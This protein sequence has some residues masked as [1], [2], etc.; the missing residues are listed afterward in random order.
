MRLAVRPWY[1]ST[2]RLLM[3]LMGEKVCFSLTGRCFSVGLTF[4]SRGRQTSMP[5]RRRNFAKKFSVPVLRL[6]RGLPSTYPRIP[7]RKKPAKSKPK[8]RLLMRRMPEG[9]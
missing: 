1:L 8:T 3:S 2:P 6:A 9:F 5:N 7:P 4:W